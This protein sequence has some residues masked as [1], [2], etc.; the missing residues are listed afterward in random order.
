MRTAG[1]PAAVVTVGV[2][3]LALVVA[4]AVSGCSSGSGKP[5]ASPP[6]AQSGAEP[7]AADPCAAGDSLGC[8]AARRASCSDATRV[9]RVETSTMMSDHVGV[10]HVSDHGLLLREDWGPKMFSVGSARRLVCVPG[11]GADGGTVC[12][13]FDSEP[14]RD[15]E[16]ASSCSLTRAGHTWKGRTVDSYRCEIGSDAM[17]IYYEPGLRDVDEALGR[18]ITSARKAQDVP[19]LEVAYLQDG[20]Q[21]STVDVARASCAVFD[22]PPGATVVASK[23]AVQRMV[24][25]LPERK[26]VHA[27]DKQRVKR[28]LSARA[29]DEMRAR[30]AERARVLCFGA[31]SS[32]NPDQLRACMRDRP[33]IASRL[34]SEMREW[35][36]ELMGE[37][38][39]Q[40]PHLVD[41][42]FCRAVAGVAD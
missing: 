21:I 9:W 10:R 25:L 5:P 24:E 26:R 22:L 19:G 16:P 37:T 41:V 6:A 39:R 1:P 40:L 15:S 12:I 36:K 35:T 30:F 4:L 31:D 11:C 20:T 8:I 23:A 2:R 29:V 3:I 32:P 17:E 27:A 33:E 28:E 38:M 42:D 14:D 18:V 13:P 7:A 34:Q